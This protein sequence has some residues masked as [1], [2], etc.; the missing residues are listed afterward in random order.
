MKRLP[1]HLDFVTPLWTADATGKAQHVEGT[2]LVGSL[3]WWYA[4]IIRGLGGWA[5]DPTDADRG[6]PRDG[7]VTTENLDETLCAA[8]QVFGATG[9][10]KVFSLV[11]DDDTQEGFAPTGEGRVTTTGNRTN[12]RDQHPAWYFDP[13]RAGAL[14]VTLFPRRP[15]DEMTLL[16]LLG[17]VEFIRRNGALGSKTNL[18]YGLLA[19]GQEPRPLKPVTDAFA[20]LMAQR[21]G[22][23][24]RGRDR[25]WPDLREMFFAHV[26][27]D[28]PWEPRDFVNFKYDMRSAFRDGTT[29]QGLIRDES[30]R[31]RLRHFLLGT[32]R[33]QNAPQASKV[34]MALMPPT[35]RTLRTWGWVPSRLPVNVQREDIVRLLHRQIEVRPDRH[36]VNWREFDSPRD[37]VERFTDSTAY[38]NSLMEEQP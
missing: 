3:R 16:L 25:R 7:P 1:L 2:G 4:A 36:I 10:A 35:Q 20:G 6:C 37:T 34:K 27:L 11:L 30:A 8:C 32:V 21:A 26:S 12:L 33:G 15:D 9:W 23:G 22:A 18:G 13:G 28:E 17:L 5:C 24:R 31:K 38:L 14:A 19:W 29:I